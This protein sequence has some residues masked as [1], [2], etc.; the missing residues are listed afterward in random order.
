MSTL[1]HNEYAKLVASEFRGLQG[2]LEQ[3]VQ[4]L[5]D[6]EE[7]RELMAAYSQRVVRRI[8]ATD[9]FVEDG[10]MIIHIPNTPPIEV[11]GHAALEATYTATNQDPSVSMPT[12]HNFVVSIDGDEAI[13]TCLIELQKGDKSVPDGRTFS[14]TGFYEDRLRRVDGRWKFV[15]RTI[16]QVVAGS[17][18]TVPGAEK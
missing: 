12:L 4:E 3:R 14:A 10:A 1:E 17:A 11:R 13:A 7:I 9:M 16:R 8:S 5:C 2:S 6:R 15:T 18:V